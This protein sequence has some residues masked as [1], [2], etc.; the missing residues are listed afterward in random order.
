MTTLLA[1]DTAT[2]AC[3]VA[4]A[5]D[6]EVRQQFVATPREH[7]RL[8]LPMVDALLAEAGI[9]LSAVDAIAF[10]AGPGSFTGL[11]IGFGVVQGLAFGTDLPVI[12]LSTLAVMARSAANRSDF[13]EG[14]VLPALDAR[15]G[16]LYWGVYRVADGLVEAVI[17]DGVSAPAAVAER[18]SGAIDLGVGD[19]WGQLA[20]LL[21]AGSIDTALT[22]DAASA[23][24]L[25]T[26]IYAGGGAR[27]VDQVEL[28]YIR[29]EVTWKKRQKIRNEAPGSP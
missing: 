26:P 27:P 25:A 13:I 29:N 6:G 16:E 19:G 10:T 12:P 4:L 20:P 21:D 22:P 7:T 9:A 5:V 17:A 15:M 28:I 24:A 3:S 2:T 11:R 1:I 14:L 8:V 18:V 23:I